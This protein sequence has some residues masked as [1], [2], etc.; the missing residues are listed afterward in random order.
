MD[1]NINEVD[2]SEYILNELLDDISYDYILRYHKT[3]KTKKIH[4]NINKN[5]FN[6][7]INNQ[8]IKE[9]AFYSQSANSN[10]NQHVMEHT[11]H[12]SNSN[13][14]LDVICPICNE[15]ISG[16]RFAPHLEKCMNGGSRR[17]NA[18]VSNGNGSSSSSSSSSSHPKQ[19]KSNV[20][21][22]ASNLNL[23]PNHN[24]TMPPATPY[25]IH[26][27]IESKTVELNNNSNINNNTNRN[28]VFASITNQQA[29]FQVQPQSQS[30][31]SRKKLTTPSMPT[32]LTGTLI[33]TNMINR[34]LEASTS[35]VLM[36]VESIMELRLLREKEAEAVE[37][38]RV[39]GLVRVTDG[40]P[41]VAMS[42]ETVAVPGREAVCVD[43]D[44][45]VDT[46]IGIN[47]DIDIDMDIL[48]T[49]G[50]DVDVNENDVSHPVDGVTGDANVDMPV[51]SIVRIRLRKGGMLFVECFLL[52]V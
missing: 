11:Q 47:M 22:V 34:I 28:G 37:E 25:P 24:S 31:P 12:G 15:C 38:T 39:A 13:V 52:V 36:S 1:I 45:D 46:D 51:T 17:Q 48:E 43:P 29:Q 5:I 10:S 20:S 2:I 50:L 26:T 23:N 35:G 44:V 49:G 3:Y 16:L 6:I 18:S 41:D 42:V 8:H 19:S 14:S 4:K 9:Y 21:T 32:K 40:H 30:Q 33:T 27:V 7:D